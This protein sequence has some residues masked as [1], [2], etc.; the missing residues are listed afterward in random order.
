MLYAAAQQAI[1]AP[2]ERAGAIEPTDG[3]RAEEL[4][5]VLREAVWQ[6]ARP[7]GQTSGRGQRRVSRDDARQMARSGHRAAH[8]VACARDGMDA[9]QTMQILMIQ[10]DALELV[11]DRVIVRMDHAGSRFE[12]DLVSGQQ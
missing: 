3:T 9:E 2:I 1:D 8:D 10:I 4:R 6:C 7:P 5:Q 11:P 12:D